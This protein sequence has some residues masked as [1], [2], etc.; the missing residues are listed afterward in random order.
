MAAFLTTCLLF[1]L[2]TTESSGSFLDVGEV[3]GRLG[4]RLRFRDSPLS[5]FSGTA[6]LMKKEFDRTGRI[7]Q[8]DD[9]VRYLTLG[10]PSTYGR[11]LDNEKRTSEAYPYLLSSV[12]TAANQD[13]VHNVAQPQYETGGLT[14]VSLCTQ[15]FVEGKGTNA[16]Q[17]QQQTRKLDDSPSFWPS[18][19]PTVY[20][21]IT[22]EYAPDATNDAAMAAYKSS[23]KLLTRRLRKRYPFA[24]I[25]VVQ[26]WSPLD[27]VYYDPVA[28]RVVS[29]AD[30][31]RHEKHQ[32]RHQQQQKGD[33]SSLT[34]EQKQR[35]LIEAMKKQVWTFRD[36][37]PAEQLQSNELETTMA[38]E[39]GTIYQMAKPRNV[40]DS[41]DVVTDWF[42]EE[43][44]EITNGDEQS[45]S[46]SSSS[47]RYTLS[48]RG[49]AKVAEGIREILELPGVAPTG[50]PPSASA[51]YHRR[52]PAHSTLLGSWGSGDACRLWFETGKEDLPDSHEYSKGLQSKEFHP[53]QYALE[54]VSPGGGSL[55][56]RNPFD[57]DRIVYLTYLTTS[58]RAAANKVYPKTKV[59]MVKQQTQT[60]MQQQP[61]QQ[62]Q[63]RGG[64]G[65]G[66]STSTTLV[67]DP[68]H[69]DNSDVTHRTRTTAV[70][71][72]EAR[73]AGVLE[74]IPLE[75]YT[76]HNF[77]I[78]G[79]SFLTKEKKKEH[80]V[81]FEFATS[82]RRIMIEG[83]DD[84]ITDIDIDFDIE[85]KN[86]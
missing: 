30:W 68:S 62:M 17:Q 79:V 42:L 58:A 64:S 29:F 80:D 27:L 63:T 35:L 76:V 34:T 2:A 36:L 3:N 71:L 86:Q 67:L 11:G 43:E 26:L 82:P 15:S 28:N 37:S 54:V 40:N 61:Q 19:S 72:V 33:D 22:L 41:L 5:Q 53:G 38:K 83:S 39:K 6:K 78:V 84:K 1:F 16:Q 10:G 85:D 24:T 60:Q 23:M 20:D 12:A 73:S 48:R 77:R 56:V 44:I 4:R 14:F 9:E 8:T 66:Q 65:P 52:E 25:I 50:R 32:L 49:H 45:S 74:F 81:S 75:Q 18:S 57:E 21:V 55:T 59:S 51:A 69:D 13:R 46:S 47:L 70:G 7:N 31:K